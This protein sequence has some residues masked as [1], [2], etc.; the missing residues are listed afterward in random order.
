MLASTS[1]A[2]AI[3]DASSRIVYGVSAPML[4]TS[5]ADAGTSGERR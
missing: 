3:S 4:K 5:L 2:R 1:N